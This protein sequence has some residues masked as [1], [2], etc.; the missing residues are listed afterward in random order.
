[1]YKP[2][3]LSYV[4]GI[5]NK[6]KSLD[7]WLATINTY[8]KDADGYFVTT[9]ATKNELPEG[10]RRDFLPEELLIA[11]VLS[12]SVKE[13][14]EKDLPKVLK[15]LEDG[16]IAVYQEAYRDLKDTIAASPITE[17]QKQLIDEQIDEVIDKGAV[18][19]AGT[20]TLILAGQKQ[21]VKEGLSSQAVWFTNNY[22]SRIVQ[23]KIDK[24]IESIAAGQ[25]ADASV[26]FKAL[27]DTVEKEFTDS[28]YWQTVSNAQTS[29]A[30][31]YGVL[32]SGQALG[33]SKYRYKAVLDSKTTVICRSLD[34]IEYSVPEAVSG[35]ENITQS[36]PE[37]AIASYPF[38]DPKTLPENNV[39]AY[40]QSLGA[41]VP[42]QHFNC[43]SSLLFIR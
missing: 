31:H 8:K 34:G 26:K 39:K 3:I 4:K 5:E 6:S 35:L 13:A 36:N 21:A 24:A 11:S 42:P 15:A 23:P 41:K 40:L 16:D 29:R 20:T 28:P 10:S 25:T 19:G 33:Y 1:M 38:I 22:A 7:G 9:N 27:R 30:Y 43:R 14:T 18:V 12:Q 17:T 37:A 32:K 2:D